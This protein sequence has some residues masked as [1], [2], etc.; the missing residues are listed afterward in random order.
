MLVYNSGLTRANSYNCAA[1]L[2]FG[3]GLN[4]FYYNA[5]LTLVLFRCLLCFLIMKIYHSDLLKI[6]ICLSVLEM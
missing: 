3:E 6:L 5:N 2:H 1:D 4:F